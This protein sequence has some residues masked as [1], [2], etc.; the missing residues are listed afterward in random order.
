MS[1]TSCTY[2]SNCT[3]RSNS[4]T[5]SNATFLGWSASSS[6]T[7]ASYGNGASVSNLTATNG[8]TVTLYAVWQVQTTIYTSC[9]DD[10]NLFGSAKSN[11]CNSS[12]V[13]NT[14][15]N[16]GNWK[17]GLSSYK[18]YA[19]GADRNSSG[20]CNRTCGYERICVGSQ[21]GSWLGKSATAMKNGGAFPSGC[22]Y[23]GQWWCSCNSGCC[24]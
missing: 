8:G 2:G 19:S 10:D 21:C 9:P 23:G 4:F 1:N 3:L 11:T 22:S 15:D 14:Y 5:K 16:Y 18:C 20:Y 13:T 24:S 6:A 7:S 12:S 17:T